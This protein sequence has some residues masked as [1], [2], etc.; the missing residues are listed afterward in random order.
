MIKMRTGTNYSSTAKQIIL[1]KTINAPQKSRKIEIEEK[2][3]IW[4]LLNP[5]FEQIVA[6]PSIPTSIAVTS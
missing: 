6:Y 3:F 2:R 5:H 1:L 4:H